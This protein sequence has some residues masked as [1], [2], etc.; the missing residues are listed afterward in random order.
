V[1]EALSQGICE[2]VE[3]HVSSIVSRKKLRVPAINID[4]V[5]DPLVIEVIGK[6]KKVGVRLYISDFSLDTGIPSI[7]VLA[8]DPSTFPDRSEI[9]WTAG[10]TPNPQKAL[11][12]AMTT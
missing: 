5:T 1:E 11:N 2:I 10:T 6:Y 8:Y 9:V 4:S 12:R 3:R 7:G